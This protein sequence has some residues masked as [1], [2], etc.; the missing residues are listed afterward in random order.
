MWP[1]DGGNGDGG[2]CAS[3]RLARAKRE[4]KEG[5]RRGGAVRGAPG[6]FYRAREG[7]H[8]PGDGGERAAAL[9]AVCIG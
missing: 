9:M 5:A 2:R 8:A 1:G 4:A 7:A 6:G 3:E